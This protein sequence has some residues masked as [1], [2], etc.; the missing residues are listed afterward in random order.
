MIMGA[1]PKQSMAFRVAR[2][3]G[4][5]IVAVDNREDV[6]NA[7]AADAF[8]VTDLANVET[9]I[10]YAKIHRID[11]IMTL[12]ADYPM[13]TIGHI[14]EVMGLPG[15]SSE[16][17]C[18]ATNKAKMR[19]A[20]ERADVPVPRWVTAT[21]I[22]DVERGIA[23][24]AGDV[25]IKP[26]SSSGSRGVSF[27]EEGCNPD[28]VCWAF[29]RALGFDSRVII[30]EAI[31]GPEVSVEAVT[32]MGRTEIVAVTD[33]VTTDPPFLVETGHSQPSQLSLR[34]IRHVSEVAQAGIN[35]LGIDNSATHTE[36]RVCNDGPRILEIGPRLGGGY[37]SSHLVQ[38]STGVDLVRV[39]ISL[40]LGECLD[41]EVARRQGAAIRF[42]TPNPGRIQIIQGVDEAR[43]SEGVHVVQ[44]DVGIGDLVQPL[45][46]SRARVGHV[47]ATG[48]DAAT[49]IRNAD[50]AKGLIH[51][52]TE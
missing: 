30:E 16:A 34:T 31:A 11:G 46:D 36:I 21:T 48:E 49:A 39:A 7:A 37:I 10:E 47:I 22:E 33:K 28:K 15:P 40:A 12:A 45:T 42:L 51:V 8:Y 41:M 44:V 18:A 2:Q 19:E 6:E 3:M 27:I 24:I 43:V 52:D 25:V 5:R 26:V 35:A 13:R 14:C 1:G 29:E 38:L 17:A 32:H 23:E 4:L 50:N 9:C 20:L